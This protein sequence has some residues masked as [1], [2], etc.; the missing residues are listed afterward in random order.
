MRCKYLDHGTTASKKAGRVGC[1]P[2]F[3]KQEVIDIVKEVLKDQR[4]KMRDLIK[5]TGLS[6]H[7]LI[8]HLKIGAIQC[9]Q[10]VSTSPFS[11]HNFV[12]SI[13]SNTSITYLA[14]YDWIRV[15][16][17]NQCHLSDNGGQEHGIYP[18]M[19]LVL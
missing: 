9:P 4:T 17:E 1:K 12:Q 2:R 18:L 3:M 10:K 11:R 6:H 8:K 19:V 14:R 15:L 13:R 7:L 16:R 5:A